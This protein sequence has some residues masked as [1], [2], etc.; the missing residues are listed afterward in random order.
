M[1]VGSLRDNDNGNLLVENKL[2]QQDLF[3]NDTWAMG[4]VTLNLGARWDR[5]RGWMPE[6]RQLAFAIG[7]VNVAEQ[8]FAE[9]SFYTWNSFGPRAGITYDIAGDGKT[10]VKASY[11]LFWHNPGPATTASANPNATNK[12]VTY[13]WNDANRDKHFQLGEEVGAPTSSTLAG[14]I[15]FDPETK[16]PYSHDVSVYLERQLASTLGARVGF[17]Y[18]TEDDLI[19]TSYNPFRPISAYTVPFSFV[20]VGPDGRAGGTDDRTITLYGVPAA[21][22]NTLFPDHQRRDEHGSLLA[23]QDDRGIS[24]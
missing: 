19:A 14:N 15:V 8:T 11:G 23:L 13:T 22:A 24:Q 20:D 17:V 16:Q 6:Q 2:D 4:R 9:R 7:P 18:K 21:N 12:S 1:H 10:V 3:I 5:Y